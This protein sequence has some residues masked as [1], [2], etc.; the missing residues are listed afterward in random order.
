MLGRHTLIIGEAGVNHNGDMETARKMIDV[1][2][3]AGVDIVKFQTSKT[4]TSKFA[5]KA[6]YQKRET[7]GEESQLDMIKKLRF[8]FNEYAELKDYCDRVGIPFLSTP[9]DME[10]VDFLNDL[11]VALWKIPSGEVVNL[12]YLIKIAKT[13]KKVIMSTGMCILDEIRKTID[14]LNAYGCTDITLLHCTTAYPAPYEDVNLNAMLTLKKEFGLNVGYS[15]HTMG[16]EV[17]IAAVA[18]G[19]SVIEKHFTLDR[20]MIGPDHKAS[21]E[22]HELKAMVDAI[23]N[24]EAALGDGVKRVAESEANNISIARKCL[25]ANCDIKKGEFFTENNIIP[26]HCGDGISPMRWFEVI[27]KTAKRDFAEDEMIEL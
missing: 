11:G 4:S 5:E 19:A 14:I 9:F 27:G 3:N 12:P 10:S 16:I 23:R 22:P 20:N 15:D 8:S 17:P 1:A 18:L 25:V 2:Q 6:E 21:L 13:K 7:G 26:K 24:I